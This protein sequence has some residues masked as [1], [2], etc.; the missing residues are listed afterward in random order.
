MGIKEEK[1]IEQCLASVIGNSLG[2][3]MDFIVLVR[4][5]HI[6]RHGRE[7]TRQY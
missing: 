3:P 7:N 1:P 4:Y 6:L 2:T 5:F